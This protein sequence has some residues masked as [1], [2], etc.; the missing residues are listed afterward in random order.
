MKKITKSIYSFVAFAFLA[1]SLQAQVDVAKGP[2]QSSLNTSSSG[3]QDV[4]I[5]LPAGDLS[6]FSDGIGYFDR[7]FDTSLRSARLVANPSEPI[8][9]GVGY[10]FKVSDT[11]NTFYVSEF[12]F[13]L[14]NASSVKGVNSSGDPAAS[15]WVFQGS[16]D[17]TA[18]DWTDLCDAITMDSSNTGQN[19][20]IPLYQPSKFKYYRFVLAEAWKPTQPWTHMHDFNFTVLDDVAFGAITSSNTSISGQL[21]IF[22]E[23]TAANDI[24]N[25]VETLGSGI[26]ARWEYAFSDDGNT[27]PRLKKTP[28]TIP[29]EEG[30][31]FEVSH[32]YNAVLISELTFFLANGASHRS[33]EELP[34]K[35]VFQGSNDDSNWNNLSDVLTMANGYNDVL[36]TITLT[37]D[38]AYRYY[39]FVLTESWTSNTPYTALKQINFTVT[40]VATLSSAATSFDTF[41]VYPNPTNSQINI[42]GTSTVRSVQLFDLTGTLIYTAATTRAIDVSNYNNGLYILKITAE[43]GTVITKKVL[44][45]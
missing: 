28:T 38:K 40:D 33:V 41:T 35:W 37:T 9:V 13:N 31:K 34:S 45:N 30:Y 14:K 27:A 4:F 15:K 43:D 17:E 36:K 26:L 23:T 12:T 10:M 2:F 22:K 32:N 7:M 24:N 20:S 11:Y 8:E 39:R 44:V 1:F 42:Q 19:V 16:D 29:A 6:N 5:A 21:N 3:Q 18:T 25:F